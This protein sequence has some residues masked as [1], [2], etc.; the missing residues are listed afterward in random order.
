DPLIFSDTLFKNITLGKKIPDKKIWEIL[1]LVH[2]SSLVKSMPHG[3]HSFLGE[4]GNYLSAGQ[5]QLLSLARILVLNPKILI[6]DE[7]TANIDS[8]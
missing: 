4:E 3:L 6:L 7:A 8:E 2:L 1:D 5:K